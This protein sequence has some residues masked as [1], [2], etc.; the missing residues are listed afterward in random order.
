MLKY[1]VK[2]T[3]SS[4]S[5]SFTWSGNGDRYSGLLLI[6]NNSG[7]HAIY[8]VG[9]KKDTSIFNSKIAGSNATVSVNISNGKIDVTS[10]TWTYYAII[11]LAY[12][13]SACFS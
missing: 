7:N 10:S 11:Y 6:T 5:V 12:N 3:T 13:D 8:H 2:A 4:S 9:Y 1:I